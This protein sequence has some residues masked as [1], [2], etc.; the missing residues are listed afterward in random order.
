ML[1]I[2]F[3]CYSQFNLFNHNKE[4]EGTIKV[5]NKGN[6]TQSIENPNVTTGSRVES[7]TTIT[8]KPKPSNDYSDLV[9]EDKQKYIAEVNGKKFEVKPKDK[10][11]FEY[12][13]DYISVKKETTVNMEIDTK[14]LQPQYG[15]GVGVDSK[16][17][18]AFSANVRLEKSPVYFWGASN[19]KESHMIGVGIYG[20]FN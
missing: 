8:A 3:I 14:P 10:E 15:L 13:E 4:I 12:G 19:F 18:P 16:G 11:S 2:A 5:D 17:N 7:S 9:I 20:N 1:L 6:V